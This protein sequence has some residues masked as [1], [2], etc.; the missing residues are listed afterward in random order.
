MKWDKVDTNH[1][2]DYSTTNRNILNNERFDP[3]FYQPK[4][5]NLIKHLKKNDSVRLGDFCPLPNRGVQPI[6]DDG[7]V[8]VIN[9]KHLGPTEIDIQSAEKTT[10]LFYNS[11]NTEK[12]RLKQRDV[13][14]YSTG[15]YVGRTNTYLENQKGIASNHVTIIRPDPSVCNPVYLAL[16][17]NSSAGLMQTDQRASGSTQR[18]IYPQEIIKYEIFIPQNKKGKPDLRWQKKLVDKI[19]QAYE[20]KKEARQKLQKA[21]KLV[22]TKFEELLD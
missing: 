12:A 21:K 4:F 2:L 1:I 3:E 20:A 11:E 22:E 18:E 15:A 16:F 17:L 6:Y 14:M 8:L 13:L 9:S 19:I 7:C 5:K 10:K